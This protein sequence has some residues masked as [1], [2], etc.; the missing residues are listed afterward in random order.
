M[1]ISITIDDLD[2][3]ILQRLR[4]E[5]S[6]RGVDVNVIVSELLME[7]LYPVNGAREKPLYHDLDALGGTWSQ[8]QAEAFMDAVAD[9]ERVDEDMWK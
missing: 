6:R 2:N 7:G 3:E 5:A 4:D 1:G 9:F 8:R